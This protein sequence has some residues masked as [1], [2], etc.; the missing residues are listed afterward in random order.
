MKNVIIAV[1]L[2]L[3]TAS[4]LSQQPPAEPK[5]PKAA[6]APNA[7]TPPPKP[8]PVEKRN[9]EEQQREVAKN[10]SKV[11]YDLDKIEMYNSDAFALVEESSPTRTL[12]I[13]QDGNDAKG[14]SETEDD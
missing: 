13:P 9:I 14:I 2:T 12:V 6:A 3:F 5:S 1:T 7:P 10:L 11:A 4:C 8:A